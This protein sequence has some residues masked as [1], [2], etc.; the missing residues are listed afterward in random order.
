MLGCASVYL[1]M[2]T[3]YP[4]PRLASLAVVLLL[5]AASAFA[6]QTS[7]LG[8]VLERLL[9]LTLAVL[10]AALLC[11][12]ALSAG[13]ALFPART[14][15]QLTLLE[16]G[17]FSFASGMTL[18]SCLIVPLGILGLT[19]YELLW[20][21]VLLCLA[22]GPLR[23]ARG[24]PEQ[25]HQPRLKR[26]PSA[27]GGAGMLLV[28]LLC[29]A[30]ALL[31]ISAFAPPLVYD[32]TEYHLG[33]LSRYLR[34]G[35]NG[36]ILPM[37]FN[38]YARFPFPIEGLYYF[39]LL[40]EQPRDFTPK[41]LNLVF[42]AGN[43]LLVWAWLGRLGLGLRWRLLAVLV[44]VSHP[45]LLEVSLDAYIDAPSAFYVFSALY[46]LLL[47]E[48]GLAVPEKQAPRAAEAAAPPAQVLWDLLPLAGLLFGMA[49][50]TKYTVA[51]LYLLPTALLLVGL[52][53]RARLS[54]RP[55]RRVIAT[56]LFLAAMPLVFWLG[57]NV[58]FYS[59]PLEPFFEK[60]FRPSD[61]A[62]ISR[63]T[64]YIQSHYPQPLWSASYWLTLLPRLH[65]LEWY[66]LAP[67]G[68]VFLVARRSANS[69]LLLYCLVAYLLWNLVRES[70]NR[71]LL[72][73]M[74]LL[75]VLDVQV[76]AALPKTL[77]RAASVW[78]IGLLAATNLIAHGIRLGHGGE[79]AYLG[80]MTLVAPETPEGR[81]NS[82]RAEFYRQN[83]GPL[84]E[85]QSKVNALLGPEAHLLLVYEARPYLFTHRTAYN[86]VFD[87]SVLISMAQGARSVEELRARLRQLKVTHVLVNRE[88]LL[89]FIEQYARPG[90]LESLGISDLRSQF[91]RIQ[92]PED[93]YPP[94]YRSAQ[95]Q[96]L[97]GVLIE[98][99]AKSREHA[100]YVAGKAPTEIWVAPL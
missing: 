11:A 24:L 25:W 4:R 10:P 89:R 34:A 12:A 43:A 54:A 98:F 2:T 13:F 76:L 8:F 1:P 77:F 40:L 44:L 47:A 93:L 57:K 64:F 31:V 38:F 49:L 22:A 26:P 88:E 5:A 19:F 6:V 63:E 41:L 65:L 33:A 55:G 60:I 75:I 30:G 94:F 29:F 67:L 51:Q 15:R 50:A 3:N 74:M 81:M 7:A 14:W 90:Q 69:R 84:G 99:L 78:L 37:P 59:N 28:V 100:I 52:V 17:L 92:T 62:A 27:F 61:A 82:P 96:A 35:R 45:V 21:V 91:G 80:E 42:V 68:G 79:F 97:R 53:G 85:V 20:A 46:A 83:L 23:L 48:Q 70:Q 72:P 36:L 32:V 9:T 71:F 86:T 87:E 39:G 73:V 58:Y 66:L 18:L 16:V 56:T 95:W